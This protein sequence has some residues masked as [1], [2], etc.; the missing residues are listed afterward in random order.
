M[1]KHGCLPHTPPLQEPRR[2]RSRCEL[3]RRD[4]YASHC[5]RLPSLL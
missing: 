1:L 3:L 4:A 2:R 5:L